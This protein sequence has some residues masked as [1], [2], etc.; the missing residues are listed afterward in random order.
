MLQRTESSQWRI[1]K[2]VDDFERNSSLIQ[3]PSLSA[4][5]QSVAT[6]ISTE[7]RKEFYHD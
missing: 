5:A 4:A 6:K 2:A 3:H 1:A 7:T